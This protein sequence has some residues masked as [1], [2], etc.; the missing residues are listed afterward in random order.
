VGVEGR[1]MEDDEEF[2]RREVV[3]EFQSQQRQHGDNTESIIEGMLRWFSRSDFYFWNIL[4]LLRR[5]VPIRC[6]EEPNLYGKA[7][8]LNI[9]Y[10]DRKA[11]ITDTLRQSELFE[12]G[13]P[14]RK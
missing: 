13:H 7:N 10:N 2:P 14:H 1:P 11:A 12:P 4:T 6:L 9:L 8:F 5:S 3:E